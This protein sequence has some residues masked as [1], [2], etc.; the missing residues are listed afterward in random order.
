MVK[1][2]CLGF[3]LVVCRPLRGGG[4]YHPYPEVFLLTKNVRYEA[5]GG[6]P[7]TVENRHWGFQKLLQ[8]LN[9]FIETSANTPFSKPKLS[10]NSFSYHFQIEG[11]F[12]NI[13]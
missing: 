9:V 1:N 12:D 6:T 11:D 7:F 13:N 4:G 8:E 2:A 3:F 5:W 10:A